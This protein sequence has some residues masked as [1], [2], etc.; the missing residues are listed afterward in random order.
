M[1][2]YEIFELCETSSKK[3]CPDC[4]FC[5]LIG[6]VYCSR[7]RCLTPSQSTKK[8]DKK[9]FDALS[10]PDYHQKEPTPWCQ[11]WSFRAATNVLQ[12]QGDV[13]WKGQRQQRRHRCCKNRCGQSS[14]D[15]RHV[16]K[17]K[18]ERRLSTWHGWKPSWVQPSRPRRHSWSDR[19]R[20][21]LQKDLIKRCSTWDEHWQNNWQ[22]FKASSLP[23][24]KRLSP[25]LDKKAKAMEALETAQDKIT[26]QRREL[27]EHQREL[28]TLQAKI[29]SASNA[30]TNTGFREDSTGV[31]LIRNMLTHFLGCTQHQGTHGDHRSV[32]SFREY[33][34]ST[35]ERR[36]GR[37]S[38]RTRGD[39]YSCVDHSEKQTI[40]RENFRGDSAVDTGAAAG[41]IHEMRDVVHQPPARRGM[42]SIVFATFNITPADPRQS[43]ADRT[44]GLNCTGRMTELEA[45]FS[46]AG[47][48]VVAVQEDKSA[49]TLSY[50]KHVH[51]FLIFDTIFFTCL[52]STCQ[53]L[54][55]STATSEWRFGWAPILHTRILYS[56]ARSLCGTRD[57][58]HTCVLIWNA[59]ACWPCSAVAR[60][61]GGKSQ[62]VR[63]SLRS[64][65]IHGWAHLRWNAGTWRGAST[66]C[67]V[68]CRVT[69]RRSG[70]GSLARAVRPWVSE[71]GTRRGHSASAG[72]TDK[73]PIVVGK[74][75]VEV[76]VWSA[77]SAIRI[78]DRNGKQEHPSENGR[79]T[80][81]VNNYKV[82]MPRYLDTSTKTQMA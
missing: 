15:D 51:C 19:T 40:E 80:I 42:S 17:Y 49:I 68:S 71:R 67:C 2:N 35:S 70:H 50:T 52:T 78:C 20:Q 32:C 61:T 34:T 66:F 81:T 26:Q 48:D 14:T 47:F 23:V 62:H 21:T 13:A 4:N 55:R 10:I 63:W 56:E 6:I 37:H 69:L 25:A 76:S 65:T 9:N 12:S 38:Q 72:N 75:S 33:T 36:H 22:E 60:R 1:G 44:V 27:E 57:C 41:I 5:N 53:P 29:V 58:G 8:L 64:V 59:R 43:T 18:W 79:C 82:R 24:T 54:R 46:A 73:Q 45:Q 39:T 16:N 74:D 77:D 31:T 7:G 11:T 30:K 28:D 3:Q